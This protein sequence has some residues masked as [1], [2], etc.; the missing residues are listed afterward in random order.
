MQ[1]VSS[2]I[3]T[4]VAVSISYDDNHYT[5]GTSIIILWLF[6]SVYLVIAFGK[7]PWRH[8]VFTQIWWI[9]FSPS[10]N[11]ARMSIERRFFSSYLLLQQIPACLA[12]FTW[13]VLEIGSKW[14]YSSCFLR[15]C[16]QD[17]FKTAFNILV[18][19]TSSFFSERF[20]STTVWLHLFDSDT[21]TAW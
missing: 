14:P 12:H 5:T 15:C 19:F 2:R 6:Q 20:V 4:H 13:M 1:S 21:A 11:T 10:A 8:T 17:L 9:S 16:F 3:W 7:S 18:K